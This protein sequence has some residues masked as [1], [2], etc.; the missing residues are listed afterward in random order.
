VRT[1]IQQLS[2]QIRDR[3][4][5]PVELT[6]DCLARIE[7][8]NP[9]LNAFIT[10]LADAALS[11]A[12]RAEQ[13]I[14]SAHYRGPLHGIPIGLKDIVDTV[15]VRTTGGSELFKSR[16]PTEDAEVVRRLRDAGAIILGKQNLHEFAYGGSSMISFFGAV[17]NPWDT[18]RITGGSSGGSAASVAAGLGFAAIGTDT[19]GSIRLPAAYCGLV[20]L[21]PTYGRVSTRG[22][23]PLSWS[24]DHVGPISNSVY[25][26]AMM[27]QVLAG[28]DAADPGSVDVSVPDFAAA[29]DERPPM[30]RIGIPRAFFFDDLHREVGAAIDQAIEVFRGMH[31]QT[32]DVT[33]EVSTDRTLSSAES[34]VYHSQFLASSPEL[35]QPATLARIRSAEKT[36]AAAALLARRELDVA[37]HSTRKVF[38]EVDILLTPTV[39]TPPPVIADLEAH[40][41]HLRP[42][43]LLMLRNTRPFNVWGIPAISVPCGFTSNNLPIGLQLAAAPWREGLLLQVA[44]AYE[45]ATDWH[46]RTPAIYEDISP[47]RL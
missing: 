29:L 35:Y 34:Y 30:F 27:L 8:L 31:A 42:A 43:E 46:T 22:V 15:G 23:I 14:Q 33:L 5:S 18:A 9:K 41:E 36:T 28:Y 26:A 24:F 2:R 38:D 47:S 13:E 3:T 39:P 25:D 12:R 19:A 11:D 16:V 7:H 40:P 6:R 32:R 10:V 45:Q 4:I 37:R 17:H 20:G 44:H 1:T 21:K